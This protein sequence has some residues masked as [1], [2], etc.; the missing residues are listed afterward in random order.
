MLLLATI[1]VAVTVFAVS[2]Y[3][4]IPALLVHEQELMEERIGTLDGLFQRFIDEVDHTLADYATWDRTYDFMVGRN[5]GYG[6]IDIS[7]SSFERYDIQLLL[8]LRFDGSVAL[9]KTF[10]GE[11]PTSAADIDLIAAIARQHLATVYTGGRVQGIVRTAGA[12]YRVAM[13]PILNSHGTVPASG[14]FLMARRID[15]NELEEMTHLARAP[16][17]LLPPGDGVTRQPG[18]VTPVAGG[19]AMMMRTSSQNIVY[20]PFLD[21][22]GSPAGLITITSD[23]QL[24]NQTKRLVWFGTALTATAV[25]LVGTFKLW[26]IHV[27]ILRRMETA[28]RAFDKITRTHDL[29]I[30][31]P[32]QENDELGRMG[33]VVNNML[34]ELESS[35]AKLERLMVDA[36]FDA[37][38]DALTGLKNRRA[39]LNA[40]E[41]ELSR[42]E[43]QRQRVA[44]MLADIDHFKHINDRYGHS[45]G[46]A[47]LV[48][49]AKALGSELR[50]YDVAGRYGGEEFLII[51]PTMNNVRAVEVAERIRLKVSETVR[52]NGSPQP[53]TISV[54]VTVTAGDEPLETVIDAADAAMY[55]AKQGGRNRV[56]LAVSNR[57]RVVVPIKEYPGA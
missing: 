57:H 32:I 7:D 26:F 54:G 30:R 9:V 2:W 36:Q 46:D 48:E 41:V 4:V 52:A 23:R 14:M 39:V 24:Y 5:P 34:D 13:R 19:R 40:L 50:P 3:L 22:N 1:L 10:K 28:L 43:R 15:N 51:I 42:T 25:I 11:K 53:V 29:S 38:H 17:G 45:A 31:I 21:V 55:A 49:V 27:L 56:Q 16:I 37:S 12:P 44:V 20:L 18:E 8:L 33:R 47:V 6:Q 35:R